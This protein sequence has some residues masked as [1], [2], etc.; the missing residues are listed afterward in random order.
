MNAVPA[1]VDHILIGV[2]QYIFIS[3]DYIFMAFNCVI[4]ASY[5]I[6]IAFQVVVIASYHVLTAVDSIF[7]AFDGVEVTI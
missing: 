2:F 3:Q 7:V 6:F 1:P 4:T 5:R